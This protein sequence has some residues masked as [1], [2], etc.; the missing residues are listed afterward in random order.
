LS[1]VLSENGALD[2]SVCK[3]SNPPPAYANEPI[4]VETLQKKGKKGV[5]DSWRLQC[6]SD[7]LMIEPI[8]GIN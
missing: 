8:I 7:S 3:F 1:F 4:V 2:A 6:E 5:R